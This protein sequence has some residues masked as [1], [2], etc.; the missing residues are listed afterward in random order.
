MMKIDMRKTV[1][2][3]V[4]FLAGFALPVQ[5]EEPSM[6]SRQLSSGATV[7]ECRAHKDYIDEEVAYGDM[8]NL[9][10]GR[11]TM[12]CHYDPSSFHRLTVFGKTL[13]MKNLLAYHRCYSEPNAHFVRLVDAYTGKR[14][15]KYGSHS[16]LKVY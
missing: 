16:G 1:I 10:S 4:L 6:A 15:A 11:A 14:L 13:L 3:F 5:A 2:V 9:S 8:F 7:E 12:N